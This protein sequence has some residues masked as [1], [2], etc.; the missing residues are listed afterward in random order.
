MARIIVAQQ[1][2]PRI[3]LE[4]RSDHPVFRV[5]KLTLVAEADLVQIA[6][7]CAQP[8]FARGPAHGF[9]RGVILGVACGGGEMQIRAGFEQITKPRDQGLVDAVELVGPL[10]QHARRQLLLQPLPLERGAFIQRCRGVGIVFQQLGRA[11]PVIGQIH[12]AIDFGLVALPAVGDQITMFLGDAQPVHQRLAGHDPGHGLAAH[13]VQF[14]RG[15]LDIL[16]DLPQRKAIGRA[17]V[18]IGFAVH[19]GKGE[20]DFLRSIAPVGAF[21][22][23]DLFHSRPDNPAARDPP[24][25]MHPAAGGETDGAEIDPC[26]G[27]RDLVS[28]HG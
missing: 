26:G 14:G 24:A 3:K 9:D 5:Q 8:G 21:G 16:L 6:V 17:F 12:P 13:G 23:R 11:G 22:Q 2:L 25:S 20:A 27:S 10:G 1:I 4:Q 28:R 18:P 15:V 19:V 7:M